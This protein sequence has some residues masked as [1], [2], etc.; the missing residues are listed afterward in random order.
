MIGKVNSPS[1]KVFYVL[2][3]T[4]F[5]I[6]L[7]ISVSA[8]RKNASSYRIVKRDSGESLVVINNELRG[9]YDDVDEDGLFNWEKVLSHMN[10]D[11]VNYDD[12]EILMETDPNSFTSEVGVNTFMSLLQ[13]LSNPNDKT[14][15][16]KIVS[17][18]AGASEEKL[19]YK[20][21]FNPNQIFTTNSSHE[22]IRDYINN[23]AIISEREFLKTYQKDF[24]TEEDFVNGISVLYQNLSSQLS[25][26]RVPDVFLGV[27]TEYINSMDA[28]SFYTKIVMNEKSDPLLAYA[29]LPKLDERVEE[30]VKLYTQISYYPINNGIIFEEG[31]YVYD[32]YNITND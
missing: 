32:Y 4:V 30:M 28:I 9:I 31:D 8:Y 16:D 21:K 18:I 15:I 14:N 20:N 6:V 12:F 24:A 27:H 10:R 3:I 19:I 11:R 22:N 2:I 1:P 17:E 7:T 5:I 29:A 13:S 23:L 26:I 25:T